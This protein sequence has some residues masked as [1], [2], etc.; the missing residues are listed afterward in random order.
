MKRRRTKDKAA[1]TTLSCVQFRPVIDLSPVAGQMRIPERLIPKRLTWHR[2]L[3]AQ[4]E[5]YA[6]TFSLESNFFDLFQDNIDS[7]A[8]PK[9]LLTGGQR[10]H[11][12]ISCLAPIASNTDSKAVE[13]QFTSQSGD[14][15][16]Y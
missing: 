16:F 5:K 13:A 1:L 8:L 4:D 7:I 3:V 2:P 9:C 6:S 15:A 11:D 10:T 14:N 12:V